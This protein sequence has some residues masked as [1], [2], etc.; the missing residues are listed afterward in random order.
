[1]CVSLLV[2]A[3]CISLAVVV[4]AWFALGIR[5][6]RDIDQA[7][8]IVSGL[9]GQSKLT[10]EQARRASS[11]L[12]SAG[13]LNPDSQVDVLRARVDLLRNDRSSA[14]RIL[15]GVVARE[16]MNLDAWYGLATSAK[17]G[18]TVTLALGHIAQLQPKVRPA[19]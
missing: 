11:L 2:R 5:Q 12:S 8:A 14:K 15:L 4:C 9:T 19:P 17:D 7:T 18:V 16:P 1:V 10:P 3:T 13:V 6:A